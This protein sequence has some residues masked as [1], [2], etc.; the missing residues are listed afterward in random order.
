MGF[1]HPVVKTTEEIKRISLEMTDILRKNNTNIVN[2]LCNY[3]AYYWLIFYY[4]EI[5]TDKEKADDYFKKIEPIICNDEDS[6]AKRILAYYYY[7]L[8][9]DSEK[10]KSL[11]EEGLSRIDKFS[12]GP[13]RALEKK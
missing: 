5:E 12:F 2:Y 9:N 11:I 8:Y 3:L 10:A 7:R 4:S 1:E 13:D 6:N